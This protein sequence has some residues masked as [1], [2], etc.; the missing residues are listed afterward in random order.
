MVSYIFLY[1]DRGR[2]IDSLNL[3]MDFNLQFYRTNFLFIVG[4]NEKKIQ[5][6]PSELAHL[7]ICFE[8]NVEFL[9]PT[10]PCTRGMLIDE[11]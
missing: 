9:T 7:K 2:T 3:T 4:L 5:S 8:A 10:L 11:K 1:E 6:I